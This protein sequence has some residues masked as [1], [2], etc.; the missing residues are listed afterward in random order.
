M[1][2]LRTSFPLAYKTTKE[3]CNAASTLPLGKY[4]LNTFYCWD[5]VAPQHT[6]KDRSYTISIQT[7]KTGISDLYNFS[8]TEYGFYIETQTNALW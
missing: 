2:V 4:G 6:D 7:E 3:A 8:F 1:N 5:Y